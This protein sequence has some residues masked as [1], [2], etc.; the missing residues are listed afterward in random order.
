MERLARQDPGQC[1][2]AARPVGELLGGCRSIGAFQHRR[3]R[4]GTGWR[5]GLIYDTLAG[6]KQRGIMLPTDEQYLNQLRRKVG[7]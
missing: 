4:A 1:R 6:M 7:A 2:L 5:K 3:R